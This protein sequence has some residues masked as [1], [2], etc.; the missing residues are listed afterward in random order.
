MHG[1]IR[2]EI[3]KTRRSKCLILKPFLFLL[4]RFTKIKTCLALASETCE[5]TAEAIERGYP[6]TADVNY[7]CYP[8]RCPRRENIMQ[9]YN[10]LLEEN[11]SV[12]SNR[13]YKPLFKNLKNISVDWRIDR[14]SRS[15]LRPLYASPF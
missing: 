1:E 10:G 9:L 6:K 14:L 15:Q 4:Q 11:Q 2:L 7:V 3:V 8:H 5:L 12:I 13:F